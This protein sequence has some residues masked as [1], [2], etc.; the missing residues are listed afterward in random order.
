MLGIDTS[1]EQG[2][3]GIISADQLLSEILFDAQMQHSEK[4]FPEIENALRLAQKGKEELDLI[5]VVLGPGSFTG[6][7]IGLSAA[8]GIA[9]ALGIPVVGIPS[10]A[11]YLHATHG[12]SGSKWVILPDRAK[13]VYVS[14]FEN[15]KRIMD[16]AVM[17]L[18]DL[19][20]TIK[21]NQDSEESTP[22]AVGPGAE[23]H[24]EFLNAQGLAIAEGRYNRPSMKAL[25]E[26]AIQN[27]K[28]ASALELHAIEPIYLQPAMPNKITQK[29][30]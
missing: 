13:W 19:V 22:L 18:V 26:L 29:S 20:D 15:D 7:R 12:L 21:L 28:S 24:R 6:L 23:I 27:M 30:T 11:L 3:V 2:L 16:L 9:Q 1:G 8:K 17:E 25:G 14:Y 10:E 5:A 4:L